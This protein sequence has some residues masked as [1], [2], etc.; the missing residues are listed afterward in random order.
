MAT[1]LSN[2][3]VVNTFFLQ[4]QEY[5]RNSAGSLFFAGNVIYSYNTDVPIARIADYGTVLITTEKHSV[6]TSKHVSMV[7][8]AVPSH[9]K[10]FMINNVMDFDWSTYLDNLSLHDLRIVES[11][12][13]AS[14][15]HIHA[16]LHADAAKRLIQMREDYVHHVNNRT[17]GLK[18]A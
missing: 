2:E 13:K 12:N 7:L 9:C 1:V 6:T 14:R 10:V 11:Q 5:A 8:S 4:N 3:N 15:A 17:Q 16:D 18:S